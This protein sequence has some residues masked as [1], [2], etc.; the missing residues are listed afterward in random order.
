[1]SSGLF[2]VASL[3]HQ[4]NSISAVLRI[5]ADSDI[6]KGHFPGHPVVPG[7]SMLQIVKEVLENALQGHFRLKKADQLKFMSLVEP[8]RAD[9]V[10]LEIEYRNQEGDSIYVAGKLTDGDTVCFKFQGTFIK[11]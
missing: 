11:T 10:Q 5:N 6:L 2:T 8:S 4:N 1:M 7:A 9:A 3:K